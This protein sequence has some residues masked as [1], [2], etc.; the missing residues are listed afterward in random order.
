M[1]PGGERVEL[2]ENIY[3]K[4]QVQLGF[5]LSSWFC[6]FFFLLLEKDQVTNKKEEMK[7]VLIPTLG[8]SHLSFPLLYEQGEDA[9]CVCMGSS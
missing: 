8:V 4:P 6:F 3:V 2:Q 9:A 1:L 5:L 7:T